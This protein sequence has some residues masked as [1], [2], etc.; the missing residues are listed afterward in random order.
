[1]DEL[2]K[3]M[4]KVSPKEQVHFKCNGCGACCKNVR[5]QVPLETLDVFR[6]AKHL[7]SHGEPIQC[8]DDVLETY[9]EPVLLD[10]CGYFVYFLKTVGSDDAC[11]FLDENNRCKIHSV[12][13]RA[14][15]TYPFVA[16]P[17]DDG[18]FETMVSVERKFHF[19]GPIV[20]PKTWMKKRFTQEDKEFLRLDLGPAKEIA[21]LLRKLPKEKLVRAL[22][23]FQ[24]LKY[25]DYELDMPFLPQYERN[26][27]LLLEWLREEANES[28]Q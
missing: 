5:Q 6:I 22:V 9:T 3:N 24:R 17:T 10:E 23:C 13:P 15:R 18:E 27:Q 1:M 2:Y 19:N 26:T 20:H 12:N 16:S 8:M 28:C 7:Q 14:C 4:V 25:G 21:H 11:I